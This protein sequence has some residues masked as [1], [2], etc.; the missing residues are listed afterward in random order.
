MI[1]PG[2]VA[3][4][5]NFEGTGPERVGKFQ[6]MTWRGIYDMAGNVK[7]WCF[8][9]APGDCRVIAGGGWNESRCAFGT[10]EKY[11]PFTRKETFGFRCMKLVSDKPAWQQAESPVR[12]DPSL[13]VGN[14]KTCSDEAFQVLRSLYDYEKKDLQLQPKEEEAQ[15]LSPYI[16]WERV[17][18]NAADGK[19]RVV[20]HLFLPRVGKP[21]FQTVVHF[22]GAASSELRPLLGHVKLTDRFIKGHRAW[23]MPVKYWS[24]NE[25]QQAAARG[26]VIPPIEEVVSF[27]KDF[28]R[29]LD[30]LET[31]PEVF[32]T[33]KLAYYGASYGGIW[34]GI[35]PAV[36]PV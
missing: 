33:N 32:D 27:V 12:S 31:R 35:I 10:A 28:K 24:T 17:S 3:P 18:F 2:F 9:E 14:Q 26:I 8:N 36:E 34:A 1:D 6:G 4:L 16:R 20:A 25:L 30:Y 15:D 11:P 22:A 29:A 21:P 13:A 5:S 23:V 19:K 7:E